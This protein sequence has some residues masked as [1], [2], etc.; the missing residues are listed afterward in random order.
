MRTVREIMSTDLKWVNRGATVRAAAGV[1]TVHRI[2]AVLVAGDEGTPIGILTDTDLVR[3]VVAADLH[4]WATLVETVMTP[5]VVTLDEERTV[6]EAGRLMADRGLRH[7]GVVREGRVVGVV[8]A[9]DL[10]G[11]AMPST[12]SVEDVMTRLLATIS[13]RAT[14]REAASRMADASVGALLVTGRR[15]KPRP[16]RFHAAR[17]GD[18]AG[19]L[20]ETDLVHKL[21]ATDRYPYV[22]TVADVMETHL[23]TIAAHESIDAART[24]MATERIRHLVV[25]DGPEIVGLLSARDLLS[26]FK[27]REDG[28]AVRVG[29][30]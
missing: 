8:S 11:M 20:T 17:E 28:R 18:I 26:E 19:V 5:S 13:L 10:L 25:T 4:P 23:L 27:R 1:M 12:A 6:A 2:G 9:R 16:G 30:A 15:A 21:I 3:R 14:V 29:T 7:L 24:A 22:T